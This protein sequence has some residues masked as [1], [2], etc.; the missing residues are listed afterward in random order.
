MRIVE[1]TEEERSKEDVLY[2]LVA[3]LW[4]VDEDWEGA[5][6]AALG[7]LMAMSQIGNPYHVIGLMEHTV[8]IIMDEALEDSDE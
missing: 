4:A 1:I 6:H 3:K 7:I 5:A 2:G 8:R